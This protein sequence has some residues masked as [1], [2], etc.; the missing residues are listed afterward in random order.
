[1]RA[2][3]FSKPKYERFREQIEK[4]GAYFF[5]QF[6]PDI[7]QKISIEIKKDLNCYGQ[8]FQLNEGY[9]IQIRGHRM[10][11]KG[12]CLTFFEELFHVYQLEKGLL[13]CKNNCLLYNGIE[14]PLNYNYDKSP[15]ENEAKFVA[16]K[17]WA[18][19]NIKK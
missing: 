15:W 3:T 9:L 17:L 13:I 1:M 19:F 14:Y 8:V 11:N 18:S 12:F 4:C 10:Q 6:P 7:S 5:S 2:V 16:L